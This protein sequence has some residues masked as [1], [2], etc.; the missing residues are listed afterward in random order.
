MIIT[1]TPILL[2]L[3]FFGH[4]TLGLHNIF[5]ATYRGALMVVS[6][7]LIGFQTQIVASFNV[8]EA[9]MIFI[10]VFFVYSI[11]LSLVA[12]INVENYRQVK[13]E[14]SEDFHSDYTWKFKGDFFS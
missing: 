3:A 13:L 12:S 2:S 10:G 1:I 9:I 6:L 11:L 4:Y 8:P 14:Y 5:L 7:L